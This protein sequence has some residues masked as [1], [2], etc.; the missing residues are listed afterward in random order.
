M[1]QMEGTSGEAKLL[2]KSLWQPRSLPPGAGSVTPGVFGEGGMKP[3]LKGQSKAE[4]KS[5]EV[6]FQNV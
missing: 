2:K 1:S 6:V 4:D 3:A 5:V